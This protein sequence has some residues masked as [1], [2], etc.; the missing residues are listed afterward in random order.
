ML[1]FVTYILFKLNLIQPSEAAIEYWYSK[2]DTDKLEYA[3]SHGNYKTRLLAAEALEQIGEVSSIPV[4]LS[5]VYDKVQVV[6][7]AALNALEALNIS[8]EFMIYIIKK[9]FKWFQKNKDMFKKQHKNKT[10]KHNIY[11]WERASKKSFERVKEQLKKPM[12]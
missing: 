11:R 12:R 3:L 7:L 9:R 8:D 2:G 4:L 1:Y 6:S 5:A 10:K